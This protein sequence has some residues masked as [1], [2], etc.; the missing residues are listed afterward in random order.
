MLRQRARPFFVPHLSLIVLLL[1][2]EPPL[3][4]PGPRWPGWAS[5]LTFGAV[6][7]RRATSSLNV[8]LVIGLFVLLRATFLPQAL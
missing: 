3:L 4:V 8:C 7:A 5:M 2:S 6:F 1:L